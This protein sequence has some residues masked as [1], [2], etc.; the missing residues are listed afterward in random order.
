[1]DGA[2]TIIGFSEP[3]DP[4]EVYIENTTSDLYLEDA[5][6]IRRYPRLFE[7][8]CAASLNPTESAKFFAKVAKEL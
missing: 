8:L 1:M 5:D 2:F 4:D 3:D 7:R 6:S